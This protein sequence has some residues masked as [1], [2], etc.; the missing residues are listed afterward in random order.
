LSF[1]F[2][3]F[4]SY[5]HSDHDF[6]VE[7]A[8][9]LGRAGFRVWLDEEQMLPG[10]PIK[11]S[12][13]RAL[14]AAQHAVFVVT[15]A[16]LDRVWTGWELESFLQ[17]R[18]EG[19]RVIPVL[20]I[21]RDVKRI[22]PYL[23]RLKTVDWA[24]DDRE[25]EARLWELRCGLL[26]EAP[27]PREEWVRKGREALGASGPALAAKT[28]SEG[29][30]RALLTLDR[31]AAGEALICDREPQWGQ[32]TTHA[33][34]AAHQVIFVVGPQ[35]RGHEFFLERIERCLPKDPPRAIHTVRWG[36]FL[37]TS[38]GLFF[39]A[40]ARALHCPA[41]RLAAT[42]RASAVDQ[43]LIL[44]HRPVCEKDF[45]EEAL[46]SYYTS[47]LPELIAEVDP[48][49]LPDDRVGAVKLV[50]GIAWC[51]TARVQGGIA[52]LARRVGFGGSWVEQAL[53]QQ[54]A[55]QALERIHREAETRRRAGLPWLLVSP[56]DELP[57]I[58]REHVLKSS[59]FLPAGERE[60]FVD[61]VMLGARDTEQILKRMT[62]W[63]STEET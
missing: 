37:P 61:D 29:T 11:D 46:I 1:P 59:E 56:L 33:A 18:S 7:L 26:G 58:T 19:R 17:D 36:P 60:R 41:E 32:L 24:A 38:R 13:T 47:W 15:D 20:R 27:G 35:G 31:G 30:T 3:V 23:S 55:T 22:G 16:W 28:A 8:R 52:R 49:P 34:R 53:Q 43:N 6:V 2:D 57:E 44:L 63:L 50:Q 14:E 5:A 25:P 54:A 21:P 45:E 40:L 48:D 62:E 39:D 4:L 10:E 42:L 12:L 51:P 9:S